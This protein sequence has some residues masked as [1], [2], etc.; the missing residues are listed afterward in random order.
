M[1]SNSPLFLVVPSSIT[2][3]NLLLFLFG[4]ALVRSP[5][6][7]KLVSTR[8]PIRI[9]QKTLGYRGTLLLIKNF[10][11]WRPGSGH[12][13]EKSTHPHNG[14]QG[15]EPKMH[16]QE[17]S[18]G[19][20]SKVILRTQL[21]NFNSFRK[22]QRTGGVTKTNNIR[23]FVKVIKP[24]TAKYRG[25]P[26]FLSPMEQKIKKGRGKDLAGIVQKQTY[27]LKYPC[28]YTKYY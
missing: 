27:L 19:S 2:L 17:E 4:S 14:F 23:K 10:L 1:L 9:R 18:W 8:T 11:R 12:C 16:V 13:V 20:K 21:G 28:V 26:K 6:V 3:T 5:N 24:G 7:E 25:N 15:R 22:I